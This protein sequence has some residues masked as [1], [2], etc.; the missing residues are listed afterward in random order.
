MY[1]QQ[2]TVAAGDSLEQSGSSNRFLP[3]HRHDGIL[4]PCRLFERKTGAK[5]FVFC[6]QLLSHNFRIWIFQFGSSQ[7]LDLGVPIIMFS[8]KYL[9]IFLLAAS[10]I[11]VSRTQAHGYLQSPRYCTCLKIPIFIFEFADLLYISSNF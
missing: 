2:P 10:S 8:R 9:D 4:V 6:N 1:L 7:H 3:S 5:Y 11:C